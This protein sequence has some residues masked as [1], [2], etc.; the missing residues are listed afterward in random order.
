MLDQKLQ[1]L[2]LYKHS[3]NYHNKKFRIVSNS[4][5]G[6]VSTEMIFHYQQHQNILTCSYNG[7]YIICGHI[8]GIVEQN[9]NLKFHYHQINTNN[10]LLTGVCTSSP[11]ILEN[12]KIQLHEEWQ[13]TNGDKS[14]GTSILEE[15]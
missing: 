2:N 9:G 1:Y 12:G 11:K 6:Q 14:K 5:N 8:L 4:D 7:K 15:I 3:M 10:Q 13:W